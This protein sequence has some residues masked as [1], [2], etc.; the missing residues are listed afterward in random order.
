[1]KGNESQAVSQLHG[2]HRSLALGLRAQS[3]T[4]IVKRK[5]VPVE[6][7][8]LY[9]IFGDG[10]FGRRGRF[11]DTAESEAFSIVPVLFADDLVV[12]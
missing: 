1:M 6:F 10:R 3:L 11:T 4:R 7:P 8:L 9:P 12:L 5:E 2:W